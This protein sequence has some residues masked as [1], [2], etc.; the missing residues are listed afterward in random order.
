GY[1]ITYSTDVDTDLNG[2]ELRN[3]KAFLSVAHDEYWS[4]PM[5]NA[6]AAARDAGVNLG[7]FT[8]NAADWEIRFESSSTGVADRV[9]VCYKDA[10]KDPIQGPTTTTNFRSAPVNMPEQ[11]LEGVQFTG[12]MA[13]AA[14]VP[15][16]VTNSSHW[17]YAGTGFHDGDVVSGIVGYES[18]GFLS[19]YPPPNSTNQTLLSNSPFNDAGVTK[20]QNTSIYQAPSGAWVFA[21]GTMSWSWALDD[22]FGPLR[23]F[24]LDSR[25]QRATANV[26]DKFAGSVG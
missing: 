11:T 3:H 15:Y 19:N 5:F 20:Y 21:S 9:V 4:M 6:A 1:D 7:F 23:H 26:L 2:A 14:A 16:V 18:D 24:V 13:F 12:N 22:V 8:A 10:T 17:V 25:I